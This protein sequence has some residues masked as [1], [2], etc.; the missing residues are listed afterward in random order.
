MWSKLI[1]AIAVVSLGACSPAPERLKIEGRTIT[2][3][4][5]SNREWRS[6]EVWVN[7]HYRG[8]KDAMA[9]GERLVMPLDRFVAAYGQTFPRQ[10]QVTG[11]ELTAT[12]SSGA[13]VKI[14]WGEGRRR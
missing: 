13:P 10:Q 7:N 8:T 9:P 14:D 11:I 3:F 4:N 2:V 5:D 1:A 6:V 12:D